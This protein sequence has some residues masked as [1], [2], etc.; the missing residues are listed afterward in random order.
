M[1]NGRTMITP[2]D[3]DV[4]VADAIN[5]QVAANA[6]FTAYDITV[7]LRNSN[8]ALDIPHPDVRQCVHTHM[9][10][11]LASDLYES[12]TASFGT[13]NALRYVPT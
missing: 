2:A 6:I 1:A 9:K 3:L 13:T 8:P 5:R 10:P 12:E 7:E 4:L 11:F